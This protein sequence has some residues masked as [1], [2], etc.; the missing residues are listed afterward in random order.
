[1]QHSR[2]YNGDMEALTADDLEAWLHRRGIAAEVVR[3]DVPT[4]TVQAAA[5]ALRVPA[6]HILK[7][8][9][10]WA[11]GEPVLVVAR[12][13]ERVSLRALAGHLGMSRKRIRSARPAEVLAATGYPV[14]AVPPLGH[15]QPLR[16]LIDTRVLA[17]PI[18][19]AGGGAPNA[20][21][22]IAPATLLEATDAE[23]VALQTLP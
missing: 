22:R 4:A 21:L 15:R 19:Y 9:V 13:P 8:V 10:F 18:A 5:E 16:T 6:D 14:G 11:G 2:V 12:G 17:L 23:V 1:M 3:L 7:T 20:L